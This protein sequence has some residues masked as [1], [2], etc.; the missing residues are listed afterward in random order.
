MAILTKP[1]CEVCGRSLKDPKSI[2]LGFGPECAGLRGT[3]YG[4]AGVT[5]ETVDL[6]KAVPDT[7]ADVRRWLGSARGAIR[8]GQIYLARRFFGRA[9]LSAGRPE[10]A[11]PLLTE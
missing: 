8:V 3:F 1:T 9:L 6:L 7:E 10:L 5:V 11:A 4:T 2:A